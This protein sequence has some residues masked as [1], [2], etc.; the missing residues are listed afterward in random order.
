MAWQSYV[1][2]KGFNRASIKAAVK[3]QNYKA[4]ESRYKA[5]EAWIWRGIKLLISFKDSKVQIVIG[6]KKTEKNINIVLRTIQTVLYCTS[7]YHISNSVPSLCS[8]SDGVFSSS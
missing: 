7:H 5:C 6:L 3:N 1:W 4:A 8:A 2:N